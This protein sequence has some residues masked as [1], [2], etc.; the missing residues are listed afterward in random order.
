MEIIKLSGKYFC[1]S[2]EVIEIL[3]LFKRICKKNKVK[4]ESFAG[5]FLKKLLVDLFKY[6]QNLNEDYEI[7]YSVEYIN[8]EQYLY[9]KILLSSNEIKI[10]V[11]TGTKYIYLLEMDWS[12][13]N[14]KTLIEFDD[15]GLEDINQLLE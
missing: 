10:L 2:D 3:D 14:L 8:F 7:Y 11:D 13:Y 4:E 6:A 12:N 9:E 1:C 15:D 5:Q